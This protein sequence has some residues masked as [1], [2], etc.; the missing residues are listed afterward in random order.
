MDVITHYDLLIE[1]NN[2]PFQL[3]PKLKKFIVILMS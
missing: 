1:E 2:A 3:P